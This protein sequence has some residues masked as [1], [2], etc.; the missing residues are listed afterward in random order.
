MTNEKYYEVKLFYETTVSYIKSIT[1]TLNLQK[2]PSVFPNK[3]KTFFE[4]KR[5]YLEAM[6]LDEVGNTLFVD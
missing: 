4:K 3:M 6:A 5:E 2:K 1:L